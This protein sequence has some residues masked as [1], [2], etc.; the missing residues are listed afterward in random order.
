[1]GCGCSKD[2][3]APE[4]RSRKDD[5]QDAST[6]PAPG[7]EPQQTEERSNKT[8]PQDASTACAP[9]S[10]PQTLP[11]QQEAVAEEPNQAAIAQ[12]EPE[13]LDQPAGS[14]PT[15]DTPASN[16]TVQLK[17]GDVV[18]DR[19][20]L[21]G[22]K[23]LG[24]GGWCV[25]WAASKS[26]AMVQGVGKPPQVAIKTYHQQALKW[27][28]AALLEARFSR[29]VQ[30]FKTLTLCPEDGS[31]TTAQRLFVN[32][33]DYSKPKAEPA[34]I[35]Q[36]LC[37]VLELGDQDLSGWLTQRLEA[38]DFV[39]VTDLQQIARVLAQ[40]LSWMHSCGLAHLDIKPA[41]IM[42]FGGLWKLIDLEGAAQLQGDATL[43]MGCVTPMY[44]P[45]EV[46][47]AVLA[48]PDVVSGSTTLVTGVQP[49]AKMDVWAAGVTL[50]DILVHESAF[51]DM[52]VSFQ[53]QALDECLEDDG[54]I[55]F[56]KYW[57]E[58]LVDPSPI[59]A[60]EYV[61]SRASSA[62]MLQESPE[63]QDLL[64]RML[65]KDPA[66]RMTTEEFLRHPFL[67]VDFS[68]SS[69]AGSSGGSGS[70]DP[71]EGQPEAISQD[72]TEVRQLDVLAVD[73]ARKEAESP[74]WCQLWCPKC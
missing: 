23:P 2:V 13:T 11:G 56:Q 16:A 32:L 73:S 7:S 29:E 34:V 53:M 66:K 57:Y 38:R 68:K 42:L 54:G 65:E 45:P 15:V 64:Q 52:W 63:L 6:A 47:A 20:R 69:A 33:L 40:C 50:L 37:S 31:S 74:G 24:E 59:S 26:D 72:A 41:N 35:Q 70:C 8:A 14:G 43:D 48:R 19:Y 18:L 51:Q 5:Q 36:P 46:A 58:F 61:S 39:K 30:I 10:A 44:A 25:V 67:N 28:G 21:V 1:M 12:P 27:N 9:S 4:K 60:K 49:T 62:A 3:S 17:A 22:K 71:V 55:G